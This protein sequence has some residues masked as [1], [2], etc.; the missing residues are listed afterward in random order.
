[1]NVSPN[2][3]A[4]AALR[5]VGNQPILWSPQNPRELFVG[6]QFLMSTTDGGMHWKKLG[7]DLTLHDGESPP[8]EAAPAGGGRGGGGGAI[9]SF[10]PSPMS[11]GIIWVG[12]NNGIIKL[13]H[14]HGASWKDVSIADLPNP[15]RADISAI[16]ASRTDSAAAYV[17]VDYHTTG[18]YAP[19]F[20]K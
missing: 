20:Y 2:V 12:T 19:Y 5:K 1:I 16:D 10:S 11:S 3:D 9:E 4:A 6:F 14:N 17:A 7:P 15:T 18:D 8:A 13:S